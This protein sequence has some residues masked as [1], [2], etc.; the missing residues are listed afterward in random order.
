MSFGVIR[1]KYRMS[2]QKRQWACICEVMRGREYVVIEV[3]GEEVDL[4]I[5]AGKH[6]KGY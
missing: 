4:V 1:A 5:L 3:Q 6:T 2:E